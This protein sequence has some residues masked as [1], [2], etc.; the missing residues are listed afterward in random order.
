MPRSPTNPGEQ[1]MWADSRYAGAGRFGVLAYGA[2]VLARQGKAPLATLRTLA[3]A[4]AQGAQIGVDKVSLR[5]RQLLLPRQ[6][7]YVAVTPRL[8]PSRRMVQCR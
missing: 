3:D 6:D 4:T 8:P 1:G 2:Y 5:A 7:G